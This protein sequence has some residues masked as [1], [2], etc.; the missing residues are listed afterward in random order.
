MGFKYVLQSDMKGPPNMA[1][2]IIPFPRTR[3]ISVDLDRMKRNC[4]LTTVTD[5]ERFFFFLIWA[6]WGLEIIVLI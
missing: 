2:F 3:N 4:S 1:N 5:A 6:Q